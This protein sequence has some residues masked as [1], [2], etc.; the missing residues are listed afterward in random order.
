MK[1]VIFIALILSAVA[2]LAVG[3]NWNGSAEH[4]AILA[5]LGANS[6]KFQC[7]NNCEHKIVN[8]FSSNMAGGAKAVVV[9]S[10]NDPQSD[11]HA[12]S[13]EL[14]L[15]V[16]KQSGN[17]WQRKTTLLAF[18][19]WGSWGFVG[20]ENVAIKKLGTGQL[21]LFLEG[22]YTGQGYFSAVLQLHLIENSA[23]KQI[24]FYCTAANNIGAVGEDSKDLDDWDS[25]YE[26]LPA[27]NDLVDIKVS[28]IDNVRGDKSI[29][30]FS[31]DGQKY[32]SKNADSRLIGDCG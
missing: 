11:C 3:D 16:Y 19:N 8:E 26:L 28:L 24:F 7:G 32:V 1:I 9:T 23:L 6:G 25:A 29:S 27:A 22:G 18:T 4:P 14:S 30:T 15:F 5:E 21:G 17:K 2:A 12:C 20:E 13:P 10:T 31:Y